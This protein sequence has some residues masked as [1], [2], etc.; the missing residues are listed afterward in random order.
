MKQILLKLFVPFEGYGK[1]RVIKWVSLLVVPI[2]IWTLLPDAVFPPLTE[3]LGSIPSMITN[4]DLVGNFI[5]SLW[6]CIKSMFYACLIAFGFMLIARVPVFEAFAEFARKFR[7]LPS[8]GLSFLFMKITSSVEQQMAWIMVFGITT[9][10]IDSAVGI[11]LSIGK[12]EVDYAKSLRLNDWQRFRELVIFN[13]MPDFL[14]AVTQ[15]FAMAWMLLAS[16]ENI[17][18]SSGGIGVV[19]AES[20][21]YFRLEKVY[22]IQLLI[23]FTGIGMDYILNLFSRILFPYKSLKRS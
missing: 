2:L 14:Y 15:N 7:F 16:V 10:M 21:K 12:D 11:A 5:T 19:L 23:L 6:F 20:S 9:F 4:N 1:D 18:K 13:K 22:A 8:V 17:C 3:I